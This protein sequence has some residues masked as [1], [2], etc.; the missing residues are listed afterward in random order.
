[1]EN[2]ALIGFRNRDYATF[3]VSLKGFPVSASNVPF[4]LAWVY[5]RRETNFTFYLDIESSRIAGSEKFSCAVTKPRSVGV[6]EYWSTGLMV[7]C[8]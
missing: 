5:S 3:N 4:W 6:L 2:N 8:S 7:Q 1:M